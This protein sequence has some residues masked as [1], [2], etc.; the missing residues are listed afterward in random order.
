MGAQKE[1]I[2]DRLRARS[3]AKN[4]FQSA[5]PD[6]SHAQR[7]LRHPGQNSRFPRAIPPSSGPRQGVYVDNLTMSVFRAQSGSYLFWSDNR[8]GQRHDANQSLCC[9]ASVQHGGLQA[10]RSPCVSCQDLPDRIGR[11]SQLF[12]ELAHSQH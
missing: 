6:R 12:Q 4:Y 11:Q 5:S 9:P 3:S 2:Q 8:K 10:G 7:S 1:F